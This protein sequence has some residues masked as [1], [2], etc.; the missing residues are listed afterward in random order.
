M[1][2]S[3]LRTKGSWRERAMLSLLRLNGGKSRRLKERLFL[4]MESLSQKNSSGESDSVLDP[5]ILD[6]K[7]KKFSFWSLWMMYLA[8]SLFFCTG[9]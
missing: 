5:P 3:Y 2:V 8:A 4:R 6:Q 1:I 7:E 9:F